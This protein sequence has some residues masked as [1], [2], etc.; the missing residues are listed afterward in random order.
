VFFIIVDLRES[1]KLNNSDR[2][3]EIVFVSESEISIDSVA[4]AL[5]W[6]ANARG[7]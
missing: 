2:F 5:G 1:K 3:F 6:F 7:V 4:F